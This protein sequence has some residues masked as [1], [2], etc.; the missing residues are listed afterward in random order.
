MITPL[1]RTLTE[2]WKNLLD[3]KCAF[4]L[5]PDMHG[6]CRIGSRMPDYVLPETSMNSKIHSLAKALA[7]D[8]VEDAQIDLAN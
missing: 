6:H 8:V 7:I 5:L 2:N 4:A 1:G 3:S